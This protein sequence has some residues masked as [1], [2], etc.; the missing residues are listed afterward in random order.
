ML[1]A[2]FSF[3]LPLT[4]TGDLLLAGLPHAKDSQPSSPTAYD[5]SFCY[6]YCFYYWYFCCGCYY[7]V[8]AGTAIVVITSLVILTMP[9]V[10]SAL[11]SLHVSPLHLLSCIL[12][13]HVEIERHQNFAP[14]WL[15]ISV[16]QKELNTWSEPDRTPRHADKIWDRY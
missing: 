11:Y 8:I 3:A 2:R 5:Y 6:G 15:L 12:E 4:Q 7:S 1:V 10:L 14:E 9:I 13:I 16:K